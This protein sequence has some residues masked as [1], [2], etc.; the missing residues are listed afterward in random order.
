M[1]L[2]FTS[3][4]STNVLVD[5]TAVDDA[6]ADSPE[7]LTLSLGGQ[8]IDEGTVGSAGTGPADLTITDID[9]EVTFP[10]TVASQTPG[11]AP[12]PLAQ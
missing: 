9:Q 5:L 3:A 4:S 10:I 6:L 1:T 7:T 12:P 2:T 11:N 8:T